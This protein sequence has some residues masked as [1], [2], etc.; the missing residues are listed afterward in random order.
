[1]RVTFFGSVITAALLASAAPAAA[2]ENSAWGTPSAIA[3]SASRAAAASASVAAGDINAAIRINS[4]SLASGGVGLRNRREGG[5]EISGAT[6]PVKRALIYWAVITSGAPTTAV[7]RIELKREGTGA[8]FTTIVGTQVG[9]GGS[10]CWGG[11]RTTVYRANVPLSI[12]TGNALYHVRLKPGGNGSFAGGSPW[13][14]TA[15][16]LP[17]FEG[18]S[19]VLIG[20]GPSTVLVYDSG[21]AGKM[22]FDS[23]TYT[24]NSPV[25]VANALE[26]VVHNIGADGQNGEQPPLPSASAAGEITTLNGRRIAGPGSAGVDS[27]WNGGVAGP[28][29]QLWDT[30][31]RNVTSVAKVGSSPV[32]LPFTISAP[33]DCL[34]PV[35]NVISIRQP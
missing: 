1:L 13:S 30:T 6:G 17:L 12:A 5:I 32:R 33:N 15:P 14:G 31:V 25:S 28:L 19:I 21:L 16:T 23:L 10:P 29:P 3:P 2:Q 27:D 9:I 18:A 7:D 34:V 8:A 26:V 22:F 24:L 35:A 4:A 20:T 11:N